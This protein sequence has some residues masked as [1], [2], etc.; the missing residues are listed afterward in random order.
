MFQ[1]AGGVGRNHA[2]AFTRLGCNTQFVTAVG[3]DIPGKF[4]FPE[5]SQI[6]S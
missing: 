1:R 3:N 5:N 6:V 2:E 4:L